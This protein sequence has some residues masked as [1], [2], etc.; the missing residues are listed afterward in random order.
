MQPHEYWQ[1]DPG[2]I[3]GKNVQCQTVFTADG[4]AGN[5]L[6]ARR[7]KFS[8]VN[9]ASSLLKGLRWPPPQVTNGRFRISQPSK[10]PDTAHVAYIHVAALKEACTWNLQEERTGARIWLR[11]EG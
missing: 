9:A 1:V 4:A 8:G 7:P 11:R 5:G 6:D 2:V 3:W 10:N